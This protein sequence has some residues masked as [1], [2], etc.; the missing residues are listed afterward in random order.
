VLDVNLNSAVQSWITGMEGHTF[1]VLNFLSGLSL[2]Y[3]MDTGQWGPWQSNVEGDGSMPYSIALTE[4]FTGGDLWFG[5]TDFGGQVFEASFELYDDDGTAFDTRSQS[6]QV[7]G[8]TLVRKFFGQADL[9]CDKVAAT[10]TLEVSDD[11]YQTWNTWGT[12]DES[13]MRPMLNRGGSAR[14]R[15]FR[16]TRTDSQPLRWEALEITASSGES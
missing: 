9:V 8:D 7:D 12:F 11:D 3:D 1:Y 16:L 5:R 10:S 14:R 15:A 4:F 6:D 13:R 2:A